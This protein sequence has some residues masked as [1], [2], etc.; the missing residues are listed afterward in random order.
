MTTSSVLLQVQDLKVSYAATRGRFMAVN[1]VS[2]NVLAGE[3][4]G[5]VGE[6][7]SGKTTT[8]MAILRMI[9]PP[10]RVEG[11][12]AYLDGIDLMAQH[13]EGLRRLRWTKMSM[14]PQGAMNALNPV[15]RI[16]EQIGDVIITHT[17]A[18][19]KEQL[20]ARI[21]DLLK[22]VGLP[23]RVYEMYPHELSGGMKQRV[24]IAMAI[25]LSP[26]L[27]IADE[28]TSALDVVVQRIVAETLKDVQARL[29]AGVLLIGHDMGLQAQL[30]D[31]L[32]VMYRGRLVEV[33][34][35]RDVFKDPL[36]PYTQVLIASIPSIKRGA[37]RR[38]QQRPRQ[39]P[40]AMYPTS[41]D[42]P[43]MREVQPG[44]FAALP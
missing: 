41:V 16:R 11:G 24:C 8:A 19:N 43:P 37:E 31:R 2:F 42:I 26:Q 6:S 7:G 39:T 12:R 21:I 9:K 1:G 34:S 22:M 28:P 4:F 38:L 35:V 33:G 17:G 13:G 23:E 36:H 18:Q 30:V 14:I 44:H 3:T 10:G 40:S 20:R 29:N 32:G 15:L 5:L 25:A 27:I